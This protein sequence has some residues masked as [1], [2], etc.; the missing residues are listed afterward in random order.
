MAQGLV[1]GGG[2][3][4]RS[5]QHQN[6][7]NQTVFMVGGQYMV[8][9]GVALRL[10]YNY[11]DNPVPNATLNPLFPA[12]EKSHYTLGLGWR[13]N[14]ANSLAASLDHRPRGR[15][16]Q[17]EYRDYVLPQSKR[18]PRQLQLRLL[19]PV[20]QAHAQSRDFPAF[21]WPSAKQCHLFTTELCKNKNWCTASNARFSQTF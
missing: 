12:I 6:W 9:P 17:P 16:H 10:G 19:S 4:L 18:L 14:A 7:E 21:L 13:I 20:S 2:T 15:G 8:L 11:A 5:T 3:E 1:S